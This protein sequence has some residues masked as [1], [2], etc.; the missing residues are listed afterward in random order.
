MGSPGLS[1]LG[2]TPGSGEAVRQKSLV[3]EGGVGTVGVRGGGTAEGSRGA[4]VTVLRVAGA[5]F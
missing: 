4:T 5:N 1:P 2:P 3:E